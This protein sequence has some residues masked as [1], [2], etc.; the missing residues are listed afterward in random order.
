MRY[1]SRRVE[2]L[3]GSTKL[4]KNS[5]SRSE[6]GQHGKAD[7]GVAGHLDFL[8]HEIPEERGIRIQA[9]FFARRLIERVDLGHDEVPKALREPALFRG[10]H[11]RLD[12]RQDRL[13]GGTASP[14]Q[15][16]DKHYRRRTCGCETQSGGAAR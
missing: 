2:T 1:W 6:A 14:A 3:F 5:Y 7:I 4:P 12:A 15:P 13:T 10:Q 16:A 9:E 11:P 8:V